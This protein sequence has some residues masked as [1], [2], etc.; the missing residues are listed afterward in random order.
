MICTKT[1]A[2]PQYWNKKYPGIKSNRTIYAFSIQI[3]LINF[4]LMAPWFDIVWHFDL[5]SRCHFM[6][7]LIPMCAR[8]QLKRRG[9]PWQC[10][11]FRK[12]TCIFKWVQVTLQ[13]VYSLQH[14]SGCPDIVE[15]VSQPHYYQYA[16]ISEGV[17]LNFLS[18][19][20][21]RVCV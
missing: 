6:D 13:L 4:R 19:T 7:T 9:K 21:Y 5:L 3:K 16:D 11:E 12:H 2:V 10:F 18:G 1:D 17:E 20:F 15:N 14:V 8:M